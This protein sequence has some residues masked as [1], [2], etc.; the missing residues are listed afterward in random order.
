MGL[1]DKLTLFITG[2]TFVRDEIKRAALLPEFGHRDSENE[3]R[4]KP[5]FANLRTLWEAG[6]DYGIVIIPGSGSNAMETSIRSLVAENETVLNVSAGA[7]GDLY[8]EMAMANLKPGMKAVQLK[9]DPGKAID[10]NRLEDALKQHKPNVVTLTHNETST[11]VVNPIVEACELVRKYNAMPLVDGVS[12]F[13][14]AR[15]PIEEIG[16]AMY[17]TSTQKGLALPA[18]FGLAVYSNEALEKAKGV[19]QRGYTTDLVAH[20]KSADKYQTLTTPNCALVNQLMVQLDYIVNRE[21]VNARFQ[22]H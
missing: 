21:G 16:A 4:F 13:G 17:S 14:G 2:P 18:G 1:D 19:T 7:F 6:D 20:A 8:H 10:L 9:F 3:I 11:G 5:I 12:I 15:T 22:R